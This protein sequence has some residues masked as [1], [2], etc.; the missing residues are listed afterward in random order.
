MSNREKLSEQISDSQRGFITDSYSM[1]IGEFMN[2]YKEK[3][4]VINPKYQREFRW[5][6]QQQSRF[7]ESIMLQIPL[8][9]IFI[10][11]DKKKW[12]VID[13]LQRLSTIF[14]FTGI[15]RDLKE[16]I[17]TPTELI[18]I[19]TVKALNSLKWSDLDEDLQFAFKKTKMDV[20]IIKDNSLEK[21]KAK[22]ELFQRLNQKPSIL[23]GQEYRNALFI[24]YDETVFDW[25]KELSE[26][27]NF[28]N[29]LAGLEERWKKEQYD[30]EL[31]LRL[32]VFPIFDLKSKFKKVDDYLDDSI[33]YNES[34]SLLI[35][36]S[37]GEFNLEREKEKF[38]KTFDILYAA[39]GE[40]IF[41]R[42]TGTSGQQF[43]ESY[44]ESIA[45]GLYFNIDSY[46]IE[47]VTLISSKIEHLE[48]Q[49]DFQNTRGSG[50]NTEIRI[51][52]LVPFSKK[53][54]SKDE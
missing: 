50:T 11:Q 38:K 12:E 2:M 22:F 7:I 33:F 15:L 16:E 20:K 24:M 19:K 29:C 17:M 41:K 47:D 43:L 39:K 13:G 35:R 42:S 36:L 32:F 9:S 40:S 18:D 10:F 25:L 34:D 37:K 54:F 28:V 21:S 8:P 14:Q 31:V 51:R 1:S 23:S 49:T 44:Y 3:E 45:I 27:T 53:Y 4:L 48:E 30:K 6:E 26:Y 46:S 52:K 5:T